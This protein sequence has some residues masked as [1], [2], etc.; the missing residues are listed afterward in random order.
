MAKKL[1]FSIG[2]R[3]FSA[4]PNK[5]DRKK[6]Y[7]WSEIFAF[8]DDGNECTLVAADST[9]IIIP[10]GGISL[11][12]LSSGKWIE[13]SSLIT[14][15]LDGKDAE[16]IQSSFSKTN[17][18]T[19]KSTP[20]ELLD[21]SISAFYHLANAE[22]FIQA[23]GDDIYKFD[24]CFRDSYETSPAFLIASEIDEK[25]ELFM[26]VGVPNDF[27]F[28]GLEE[29]AIADEDTDDEDE[30]SDDIDFGMF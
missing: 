25:K 18:L 23:I 27:S 2:E 15:T 6:L 3:E 13:R 1:T 14:K 21:C 29:T 28:I 19:E 30:D 4:E 22:E 10:K 7:G 8:D 9:G 11:G 12:I 5:V 20:E 26:L 16:L 24:Y 17:I